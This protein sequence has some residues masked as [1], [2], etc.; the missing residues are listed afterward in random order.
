MSNPFGIFRALYTMMDYISRAAD[1]TTGEKYMSVREYAWILEGVSEDKKLRKKL[2]RALHCHKVGKYSKAL[3]KL[4]S[5]IG[6]CKTE[7]EK[8][9][10]RALTGMCYEDRG[11]YS[12]A[13]R[14]YTAVLETDGTKPSML[15]RLACCKMETGQFLQAFESMKKVLELE[16]D[17]PQV[18]IDLANMFMVAE[19]YPEAIEYANKS[20]ELN[21]N[22]S[23]AY[24]IL[25]RAY[26]EVGDRE[27]CR[28]NYNFF[29]VHGGDMSFLEEERVWLEEAE[30]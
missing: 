17:N 13:A 16:G 19:R 8:C 27:N 22:Y 2:V 4:D 12:E 24:D 18:Y 30:N 28:R 7:N 25:C 21:D 14:E 5:I 6:Q 15:K 1:A 11:Q 26:H 3:E 10:V 9:S 23:E 20:V 29:R